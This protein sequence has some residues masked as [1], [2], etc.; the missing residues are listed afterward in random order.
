MPDYHRIV[1]LPEAFENL[2]G[3]YD[4]IEKDS[5]QNAIVVARK[6]IEAI[7]S[8]ELFPRR[9]KVHVSSR[10]A[11]RVVHSMPVPPF[12]IYFRVIDAEQVVEVMTIQH[13]ARRQPRR[14]G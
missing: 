10:I 1:I 12:I 6:L 9:Y 2:A 14:F 5:P 13:G 11:D 8:L 7:D 4:Y 3:I